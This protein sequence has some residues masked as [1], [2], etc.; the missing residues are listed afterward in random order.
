[1]LGAQQWPLKFNLNVRSEEW[2]ILLEFQQE[3]KAL[4]IFSTNK[5]FNNNHLYVMVQDINI[6]G[7]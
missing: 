2:A 7:I 6:C 3:M 4:N 1:M 5:G